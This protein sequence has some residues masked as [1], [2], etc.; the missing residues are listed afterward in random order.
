MT[1]P[2]HNASATPSG[3]TSGKAATISKTAAMPGYALKNETTVAFLPTPGMPGYFKTN[4]D[5]QLVR[6]MGAEAYGGSAIG[7][8]LVTAKRIVDGDSESFVSAWSAIAERV[9]GLG[10]ESMKGGHAVSAQEAFL[11]ACIYWKTAGFFLDHTDPRLMATWRKSRECFQL[12]GALFDPVIEPLLIPYENG[13]H[14]PGYFMRVDATNKPRPT[15]MIM[16]GGDTTGEELY[17]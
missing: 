10:D 17:F 13:K 14:L 4:F 3:D 12:A 5:Y 1:A 11:R 15:V 2:I 9:E 8:C 7:E 16:G 6:A